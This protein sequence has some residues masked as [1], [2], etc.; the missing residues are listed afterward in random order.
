M[1]DLL[2]LLACV[3][4]LL[5]LW[6]FSDPERGARKIGEVIAAFRAGLG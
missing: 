5:V 6:F 4:F 2:E 1:K 3:T